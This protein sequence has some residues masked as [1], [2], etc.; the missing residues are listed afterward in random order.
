MNSGN[1]HF[2]IGKAQPIDTVIVQIASVFAQDPAYKELP[3]GHFNGLL[4]IVRYERYLVCSVNYKIVGALLY[5]TLPY[6]EALNCIFEN[7]MPTKQSLDLNGDAIYIVGIAGL[8]L[9][10]LIKKFVEQNKGKVVLFERH[11]HSKR[12]VSIKRFGY[13]DRSGRLRGMDI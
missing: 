11:W 13:F 2:F 6:S 3:F 5:H 7:R 10:Q 1:N 12:D 4:N 8:H 9:L